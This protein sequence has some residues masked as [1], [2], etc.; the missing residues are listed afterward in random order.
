MYPCFA[1]FTDTAWY[2]HTVTP[3]CIQAAAFGSQVHRLSGLTSLD[4]SENAMEREGRVPVV[5]GCARLAYLGH[6]HGGSATWSDYE[7][8]LQ[9]GKTT[10]GGNVAYVLDGH[11]A[12]SMEDES[13]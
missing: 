7:T 6:L 5:E 13:W 8:D 10:L 2:R 1:H 12:R 11:S 9:S 4:L 3:W